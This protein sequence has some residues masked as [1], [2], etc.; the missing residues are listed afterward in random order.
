MRVVPLLRGFLPVPAA[1]CRLLRPC[2]PRRACLLAMRVTYAQSRSLNARCVPFRLLTPLLTE[3]C[4]TFLNMV[5]HHVKESSAQDKHLLDRNKSSARCCALRLV[6]RSADS[7]P[8]PRNSGAVRCCSRVVP[9]QSDCRSAGRVSL[10]RLRRLSAS[11]NFAPSCSRS[12]V[13][14][15]RDHRS[16]SHR[17]A[18]CDG[19]PRCASRT[20]SA[21]L[22]LMLPAWL[23][24]SCSVPARSPR[25]H[26]ALL[27]RFYFCAAAPRAGHGG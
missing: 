18:R 8:P 11:P 23:F 5:N 3:D 22:K 19:D 17:R 20:L 15:S 25:G 13:S 16:G 14:Q 2:L 26:V 12:A 27:T 10:F 24:S 6:G 9:P 21:R 7:F 1:A 4:Q